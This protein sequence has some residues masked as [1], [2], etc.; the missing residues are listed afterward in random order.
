MPAK[1]TRPGR[2]WVRHV[3]ETSNALDLPRAVFKGHAPEVA[4][5]LKRSAERSTRRKGTPYQSAMS[6]L[7]FFINR[8]GRKLPASRRREL[9]RAKKE[10]RTLFK[11]R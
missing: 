2:L 4:R 1:K 5:A 10:L 7:T 9:E 11:R 8:A 6:M 3:M